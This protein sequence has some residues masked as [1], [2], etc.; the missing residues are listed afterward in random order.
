MNSRFRSRYQALVSASLLLWCLVAFVAPRLSAADTPKGLDGTWKPK[1]AD[2]G[3]KAMP[4][5]I[6]QGIT[7]RIDGV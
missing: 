4:A 2:L 3:G 6:V 7:L 5:P 1:Q